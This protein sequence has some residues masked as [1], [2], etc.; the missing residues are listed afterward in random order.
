M[1]VCEHSATSTKVLCVTTRLE[2]DVIDDVIDDV[3]LM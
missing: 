2:R 3:I 1:Y